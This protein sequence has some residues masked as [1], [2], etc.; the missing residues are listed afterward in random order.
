MSFNPFFDADKEISVEDDTSELNTSIES[1]A[2]DTSDGVNI[3]LGYEDGREIMLNYSTNHQR[4]LM[5]GIYGGSGSGKSALAKIF[6]EHL[7]INNVPSIVLS[8]KNDFLQ[9]L[10]SRDDTD[11]SELKNSF[12]D[13]RKIIPISF[14]SN[15]GIHVKFPLFSIPRKSNSNLSEMELE[16]RID[17]S[18]NQ[19]IEY[20]FKTKSKNYRMKLKLF[21]NELIRDAY[22][23][24]FD[25]YSI[26][27]L[28]KIIAVSNDR[29]SKNKLK[30]DEIDLGLRALSTGTKKQIFETGTSFDL[31]YFLSL[32]DGKTPCNIFMLQEL[33][34][35]D[36]EWLVGKICDMLYDWG[37]SK[38]ETSGIRAVLII[39]EA[40]MYCPSGSRSSVSKSSIDRLVRLARHYGIFVILATQLPKDL[41]KAVRGNLGLTIFGKS[42][43]ENVDVIYDNIRENR[44]ILK[45]KV[46]KARLQQLEEREFCIVSEK[47]LNFI[48]SRNTLTDLEFSPTKEFLEEYSSTIKLPVDKIDKTANP[49]ELPVKVYF[50]QTHGKFDEDNEDTVFITF[51]DL[52]DIKE[53]VNRSI[54]E[55]INYHEL[56]EDKIIYLPFTSISAK[57]RINSIQAISVEGSSVELVPNRM[58]DQHLVLPVI[59]SIK[60]NEN[61]LSIKNVLELDH[62]TEKD[63]EQ[64]NLSIDPYVLEPEIIGSFKNKIKDKS[65]KLL[66]QRSLIDRIK[67]R[68]TQL[69][70]N[71]I[72]SI[73][74]EEI[75]VYNQ[76][77]NELNDKRSPIK[78]TVDKLEKEIKRLAKLK[79]EALDKAEQ[80]SILSKKKDKNRNQKKS[81]EYIVTAK[82]ISN[83][84]KNYKNKFSKLLDILHDIEV[85]YE[86]TNDSINELKDRSKKLKLKIIDVKKKHLNWQFQPKDTISKININN[87]FIPFRKIKMKI[88][89][90]RQEK[91]EIQCIQESHI[92][93]DIFILCDRYMDGNTG[94]DFHNQLWFCATCFKLVC[95]NHSQLSMYTDT[96]NCHQH[97]STCYTCGVVET[98][99][100]LSCD[101]C[102]REYCPNHLTEIEKGRIIKSTDILCDECIADST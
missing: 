53:L 15:K 6:V 33:G 55:K 46:S 88:T 81:K 80:Y 7:I 43:A 78:E 84:R 96:R 101:G 11:F 66:L 57:I 67:E 70:D 14:T 29:L 42:T 36:Q 58:F 44:L 24:N 60:F 19:L 48:T 47:Q 8:A 3:F 18:V 75:G 74:E 86:Q 10:K 23:N 102:S 40:A 49:F 69:D 25:F 95:E 76:I 16:S 1:V 82:K 63:L 20:G 68:A 21:F 61:E 22:D 26:S 93:G 9:L 79:D 87:I 77:I 54:K 35:D 92:G 62:Y 5:T 39:D 71:Y 73:F 38:G 90:P 59:T 30:G 41:S 64:L 52:I 100:L 89:D 98:E 31:D 97:L 27:G 56:I 72:D 32:E 13:N 65:A 17:I 99:F 94:S 91:R 83:K 4:N 45:N 37:A 2:G 85:E 51:K 34:V 12:V 50:K 28:R